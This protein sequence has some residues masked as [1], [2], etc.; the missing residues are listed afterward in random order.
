MG[1]IFG[2]NIVE[3]AAVI[4]FFISYYGLTTSRNIMKSI[5]FIVLMEVAVV[6]FWLSI[7]FRAGIRPP[8]VA[9]H[10]GIDAFSELEYLGYVADPFPQALMITAIIIGLAITAI[11]TVM[12][13]TLYRKY[14]TTDWDVA[15]KR[16]LELDVG[17]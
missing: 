3:L 1:T 12:F 16:S 7:G 9:S 2:N 5:I 11:N 6:M 8:I 14:K 10:P 15:K 4:M 13:I 17:K